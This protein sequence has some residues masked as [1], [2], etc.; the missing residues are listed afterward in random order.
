MCWL[1]RSGAAAVREQA[2]QGEDDESEGGVLGND[3]DAAGHR[4]EIQWVTKGIGRRGTLMK[5]IRKRA[6]RPG[7]IEVHL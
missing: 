7:K 6:N 2:Q 3:V 1:L 4:I 5:L